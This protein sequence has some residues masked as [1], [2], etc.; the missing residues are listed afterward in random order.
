VRDIYTGSYCILRFLD[1]LPGIVAR[2]K[3]WFA[4]GCGHCTNLRPRRN[5][6]NSCSNSCRSA[7]GQLEWT[8]SH[9]FPLVSDTASVNVNADKSGP[10]IREILNERGYQCEPLLVVPD[11]ESK[12]RLAVKTWC[13]R[14]DIDWIITTGGT[15]FGLRDRTPEVCHSS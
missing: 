10:T 11:D 13:E 14:G 7:Y 5:V 4:D 3:K 8:I 6:D 15:G 9:S 1:S 2:K 12:I